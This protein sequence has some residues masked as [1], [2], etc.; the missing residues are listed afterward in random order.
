MIIG[1]SLLWKSNAPWNDYITS[2]G[3]MLDLVTMFTLL[4]ILGIP[5]MLGDYRNE[6]QTLIQKK[7]K[8]FGH[9]YMMTSGIS[10]FFSIFMNLAT[11]PMVYHSI[12][13]ALG[14]FPVQYAKRFMSSAITHGYAMPLMWAPVTPIVGIVISVTGVNWISILPYILPLSFFGILLDWYMGKQRD[15]NKNIADLPN[16]ETKNETAAT[17]ERYG[18]TRLRRIFHIGF[19]ILIFNLVITIAEIQLPYS[20][21]TIVS[22]LVIPFAFTWC[23]LLKKRNEFNKSLLAHFSSFSVK[24]KDQFFIYLSAGFFI[25]TIKISQTNDWLNGMISQLKEIIG[26]E[27]F[28]LFLPLIPLVF[29]FIGLHPAVTVAL[30][31]ESLNPTMLGISPFILTVAML[32]GAVSA[33]LVG[34]YNATI[35]LMSNI[36]KES[37]FKV[38]QWNMSY[39]SLYIAGVMVYL[40]LLECFL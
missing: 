6:I 34:P 40:F 38:S 25:S 37:S 35:G 3:P 15:K 29:A 32:G 24:M 11:L 8:T 14:G 31:A 23:L 26:V 5:I 9:L 30:M 22:L 27:P 21:L 4:P 10:Y 7:V 19:A 33:F 18:N 28:L 13:P 36:V 12:R 2:F 39:T 16:G 20:F 17:M 1:I